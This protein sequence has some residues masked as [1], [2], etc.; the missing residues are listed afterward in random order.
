MEIVRESH[1]LTDDE[2]VEKIIRGEKSLYE[3]LIRRHNQKL[4]RTI[5]SYL[6][7]E[8]EV[9][10]A[11]QNV[12]LTVFEKLYQ[13]KGLSQ[14]STWLVRIG[15]N[16]SLARL[17]QKRKRSLTFETHELSEK[18]Y[19]IIPDL[20]NMNPEMKTIH[21]ETRRLLEAAIDALPEKYRSVY[22]LREVEGMSLAEIAEC[23]DISENNVKVRL[24][25]AKSMLKEILYKNAS[26]RE[27]F[28]FGSTRC[29]RI[30]RRVMEKIRESGH[31]DL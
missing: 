20:E 26:T 31:G 22:M 28:G 7:D 2:V 3:I 16:E 24:H 19:K 23:L 4:Y 11:M 13:Y 30:T 9:E 21:D 15:I 5:R 17:N 8:E 29:D 1:K 6:K 14:F 12:Y 27:A 10:D 18:E 25:R